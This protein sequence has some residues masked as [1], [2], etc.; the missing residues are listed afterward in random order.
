MTVADTRRA[1]E[2]LPSYSVMKKSNDGE[3]TDFPEQRFL[4]SPDKRQ[5]QESKIQFK[6]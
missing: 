4:Q 1:N 5:P 3:K 6:P 2:R